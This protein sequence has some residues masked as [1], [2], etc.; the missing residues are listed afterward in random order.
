MWTVQK[1][2]EWL[3]MQLWQTT[4]DQIDGVKC[5]GGGVV[6]LNRASACDINPSVAAR[7][8][9]AEVGSVWHAS[10]NF[11]KERT[12]DWMRDAR[13]DGVDERQ[14][15]KTRFKKLRWTI[16]APIVNVDDR[17]NVVGPRVILRE[18]FRAQ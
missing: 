17:A 16:S 8:E 3:Q 12:H 5:V 1:L 7:Q 4:Q 18:Q 2:E 11:H 13:S 14:V 10:I 6:A 9:R 15:L